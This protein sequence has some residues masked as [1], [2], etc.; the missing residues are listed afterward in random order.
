MKF[1]P[2]EKKTQEE[3]GENKNESKET[4]SKR[5]KEKFSSIKFPADFEVKMTTNSR[6]DSPMH[7]L[8]KKKGAPNEVSVIALI[9]YHGEDSLEWEVASRA[10]NG[11]LGRIRHLSLTDTNENIIKTIEENLYLEPSFDERDEEDI[12]QEKD[13]SLEFDPSRYG[14]NEFRTEYAKMLDEA[15]T[16]KEKNREIID[17]IMEMEH[18]IDEYY[19]IPEEEAYPKLDPDYIDNLNILRQKYNLPK[20]YI[21]GSNERFGRLSQYEDK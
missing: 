19:Y 16:N 21:V 13:E 14:K 8:V 4:I 6:E 15:S 11:S 18:L 10:D 3:P 12:E 5:F 7:F 9:G 17:D 20:L 1:N 2:F